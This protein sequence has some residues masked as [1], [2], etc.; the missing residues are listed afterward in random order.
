VSSIVTL[1]QAPEALRSR[2][3]DPLQTQKIMVRLD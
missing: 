1:D 3:D 2:S